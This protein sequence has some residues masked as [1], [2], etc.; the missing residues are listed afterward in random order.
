MKSFLYIC[1]TIAFIGIFD[2]PMTYYSILRI[3]ISIG[4]TVIVLNEFNKGW[5]FWLVSF[6][7]ILL[8]FNPI[9][10]IYLY[11]KG[12]WVILDI[13]C[14]LLFGIYSFTLKQK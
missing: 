14:S 8:V 4:A 9:S 1:S 2:M 3:V 5:N 6:L 11:S 13:L 12:L 10:P 7:V